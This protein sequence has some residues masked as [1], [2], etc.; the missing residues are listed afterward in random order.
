MR[1]QYDWSS[2]GFFDALT[3]A[4]NVPGLDELHALGLIEVKR[5]PK[6]HVCAISERWR[7]I[8]TIRLTGS[9][10]SIEIGPGH[11]AGQPTRS[12]A[13]DIAGPAS[14]IART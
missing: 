6:R 13:L 3:K 8:R 1:L 9:F 11:A 2:N 12:Q 4:S 10:L 14:D 7:D 5:T